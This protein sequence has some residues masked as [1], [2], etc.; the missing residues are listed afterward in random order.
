MFVRA[1]HGH[2][3]GAKRISGAGLQ[4]RRLITQLI[5]R[6]R[7]KKIALGENMLSWLYTVRWVQNQV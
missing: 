1:C 7:A 5:V 3:D 4:L 2:K 6:N